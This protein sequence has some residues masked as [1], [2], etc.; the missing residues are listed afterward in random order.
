MRFWAYMPVAQE[1]EGL[2]QMAIMQK[3]KN[4]VR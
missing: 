3:A 2:T 4:K 1:H